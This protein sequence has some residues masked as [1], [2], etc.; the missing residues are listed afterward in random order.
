M[1]SSCLQR[2]AAGFGKTPPAA[3]HFGQIAAECGRAKRYESTFIAEADFG[4]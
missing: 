1:D 3:A 4:K 2:A